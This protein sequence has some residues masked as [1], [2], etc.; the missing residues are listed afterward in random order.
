MYTTSEINT[1]IIQRSSID[2][3]K[4][5]LIKSLDID[6][7][8]ID[9]SS[10]VQEG[11]KTDIQLPCEDYLCLKFLTNKEKR[12]FLS[13]HGKRYNA[14]FKQSSGRSSMQ[15]ETEKLRMK[16][17]E[18]GPCHFRDGRGMRVKLAWI[19]YNFYLKMRVKKLLSC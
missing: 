7:E 9:N 18:F 3:K 6:L 17:N 8:N 5:K 15:N 4:L 19:R 13:C 16:E 2:K 11:V 14:I 12:L 1:A 10:E